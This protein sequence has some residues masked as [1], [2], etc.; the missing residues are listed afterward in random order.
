MLIKIKW[1]LIQMT[2]YQMKKSQKKRTKTHKL[3]VSV[4]QILFTGLV[5]SQQDLKIQLDPENK[6]LNRKQLMIIHKT[7]AI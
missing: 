5:T 7:K 1:G 3:S 2:T 4:E 6:P